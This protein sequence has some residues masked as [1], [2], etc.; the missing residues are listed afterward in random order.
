MFHYFEL[1]V[2]VGLKVDL[3]ISSLASEKAVNKAA[4]TQGKLTY[5]LWSF[6]PFP[7]NVN[8]QLMSERRLLRSKQWKVQTSTVQWDLHKFHLLMKTLWYGWK[9]QRKH[10][11]ALWVVIVLWPTSLRTNYEAQHVK[12]WLLLYFTNYFAYKIEEH[13][14]SL[15]T[16]F[17]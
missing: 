16:Y 17:T 15:N 6:Q 1:L 14:P 7:L 5:A 4:S 9:L 8:Q 11:S 10:I 13:V 3:V 12:K 2:Y